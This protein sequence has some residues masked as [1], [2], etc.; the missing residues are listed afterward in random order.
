MNIDIFKELIQFLQNIN[1]R[2]KV[3]KILKKFYARNSISTEELRSERYLENLHTNLFYFLQQFKDKNEKDIYNL[4]VYMLAEHYIYYSAKS[5]QNFYDFTFES[6]KKQYTSTDVLAD[7]EKCKF[8]PILNKDPYIYNSSVHM[9]SLFMDR[10]DIENR[11]KDGYIQK[12]IE[13][14]Y[15]LSQKKDSIA[16]VEQEISDY[17]KKLNTNRENTSNIKQIQESIKNS[18]KK[19]DKYKTQYNC[20]IEDI[21]KNKKKLR[22][23]YNKTDFLVLFDDY[24]GSGDTIVEYLNILQKYLPKRI[25]VLVFCLHAMSIA[26]QTL[27]EWSKKNKDLNVVFYFYVKDEKFFDK[28]ENLPKNLSTNPENIKSKLSDFEKEYVLET[29]DQ[30]ETDD[31]KY[32]FGYKDTQALVTNYRNT[33][34]NTFSLFWKRSKKLKWRPLFPRKE[35]HDSRKYIPFNSNERQLIRNNVLKIC[36][37]KYIGNHD[38]DNTEGMALV[39]FLIYV[40]DNN[41]KYFKNEDNIVVELLV[42]DYNRNV[43]QDCLKHNLLKDLHGHYVLSEL[44]QN[45]INNLE[46]SSTSLDHLAEKSIFNAEDALQPGS[47]Y[48]PKISN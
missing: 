5:F 42:K 20:I 29:D 13:L 11:L 6:V 30:P 25:K 9:L 15:N 17:E 3:K 7:I 34:N 14:E 38:I 2:M 39:I 47:T 44:G 26:E 19:L 36:K 48:R 40:N 41:K 12:L 23:S 1:L 46:L 4:I 16:K 45:T 8:A 31:Q 18:T 21:K 43:L 33:P 22:N 37:N 10:H 24:S 27:N 32:D 28:L 35:K